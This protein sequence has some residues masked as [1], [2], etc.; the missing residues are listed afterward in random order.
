MLAADA[1]DCDP[2]YRSQRKQADRMQMELASEQQ[3]SL[4][5]EVLV[6]KIKTIFGTKS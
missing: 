1:D 6:K 3:R 5:L 4:S 2:Q